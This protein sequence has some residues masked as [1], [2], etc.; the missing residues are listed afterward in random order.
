MLGSTVLPE[1]KVKL[2]D[3][4]LSLVQNP[5]RGKPSHTRIIISGFFDEFET[6]K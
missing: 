6:R 4:G 2:I 3:F 5:D 1:K